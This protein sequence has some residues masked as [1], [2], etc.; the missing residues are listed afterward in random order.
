MRQD[1]LRHESGRG[2]PQNWR[3][4]L[5]RSIND[6]TGTTISKCYAAQQGRQSIWTRYNNQ[7]RA[8]CD[9]CGELLFV[10]PKE[11]NLCRN[12]FD[13]VLAKMQAYAKNLAEQ[14]AQR[15]KKFEEVKTESIHNAGSSFVEVDKFE[16]VP[17]TCLNCEKDFLAKGKFNRICLKCKP[18]TFKQPWEQDGA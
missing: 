11:T 16:E 7:M 4:G 10:K 13:K 18:K 15:R 14:E 3:H 1:F 5:L 17:R 8:Y 2:H 6:P 12:C 9:Q